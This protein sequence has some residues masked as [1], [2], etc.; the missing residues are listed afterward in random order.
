MWNWQRWKT[1]NENRHLKINTV[2]LINLFLGLLL[3]FLNLVLLRGSAN[4]L[5]IMDRITWK[6]QICKWGKQ[7]SQKIVLAKNNTEICQDKAAHWNK[8]LPSNAARTFEWLF[9]RGKAFN[10]SLVLR[11]KG[12]NCSQSELVVSKNSK[13]PAWL[14]MILSCWFRIISF[15]MQVSPAHDEGDHNFD[16]INY[17]VTIASKGCKNSIQIQPPLPSVHISHKCSNLGVS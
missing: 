6:H 8:A 13:R 15:S 5:V 16:F 9:N 2:K 3:T 11:K 7:Q 17:T 10:V 1:T 14:R 4:K 12:W